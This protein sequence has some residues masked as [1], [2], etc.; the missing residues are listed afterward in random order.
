MVGWLFGF[1]GI[2][3]FV[4]YSMPNTFYMNYQFFFK[5]FSLLQHGLKNMR[6]NIHAHK[7]SSAF[8]NQLT[9]QTSFIISSDHMTSLLNHRQEPKSLL[10]SPS[11]THTE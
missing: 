5:Q 6:T 1:N 2:S 9:V 8:V 7:Y 11:V 3:T 4:G 10:G